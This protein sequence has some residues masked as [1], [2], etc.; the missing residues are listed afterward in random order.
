MDSSG[1][2]CLDDLVDAGGE[3]LKGHSGVAGIFSLRFA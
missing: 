1:F 3:A 2:M